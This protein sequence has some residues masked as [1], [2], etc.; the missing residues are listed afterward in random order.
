MYLLQL[1]LIMKDLTLLRGQFSDFPKLNDSVM[2]H[3]IVTNTCFRTLCEPD[4]L[5]LLS[6]PDN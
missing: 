5:L 2:L 6:F 4:I 1:R 3:M